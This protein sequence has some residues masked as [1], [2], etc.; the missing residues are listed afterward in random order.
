MT[1]EDQPPEMPAPAPES[2]ASSGLLMIGAVALVGGHILF[3]LLLD[4][5]YY[6]TLIPALALMTL[7]AILNVGGFGLSPRAQRTIGIFVGLAAA[8]GFLTDLRSGGFPDG[9]VDVLAYL[10]FLAG[11]ALMFVG[12]WGAKTS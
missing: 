1:P 8:I 4:E 3:G 12:A 10:V 6:G 11:S 9:F 2:K 7:L 5:Y